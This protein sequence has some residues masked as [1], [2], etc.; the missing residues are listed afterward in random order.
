MSRLTPYLSVNQ[1]NFAQNAQFRVQRFGTSFK[2]TTQKTIIVDGWEYDTNLTSSSGAAVTISINDNTGPFNTLPHQM[3]VVPSITATCTT[4]QT[5][6]PD[7]GG[8][9]VF[10]STVEGYDLRQLFNKDLLLGFWF[11]SNVQGSFSVFLQN[12]TA[13]TTT[14]PPYPQSFVATFQ[15]ATPNFYTYQTFNINALYPY[16]RQGWSFDNK[17]GLR[18]GICMYAAPARMASKLGWSSGNFYAPSGNASLISTVGNYFQFTLAELY[19]SETPAPYV[20]V[21]YSTEIQR[22]KK[23][24]Q[25]KKTLSG[26]FVAVDSTHANGSCEFEVGMRLTPTV[27][28]DSAYIAN[29][30]SNVTTSVVPVNVSQQGFTALTAASPAW[31]L[32]DTITVTYHADAT[33]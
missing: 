20:F 11:K 14:T 9:A 13:V 28:I 3:S 15:N 8:Y 23:T 1:T 32:G 16:P 27:T 4:A 29:S 21:D 2:P 5:T 10:S 12:D 31:I 30:G 18:F 17:L 26:H 7:Q 33:Y 6:F 19:P 22:A 25:Q 24:Y